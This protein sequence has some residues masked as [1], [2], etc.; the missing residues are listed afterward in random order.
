MS[1]T[2]IFTHIPKTAG[3]S[4]KKSAIFPNVRP[5]D[6][7]QIF[8]VRKLIQDRPR[9][10]SVVFGHFPYGAHV[11]LGPGPFRYLT[12]LRDPVDRAVSFYNYVLLCERGN[13]AH[14][15]GHRW[16]PALPDAKRYPIDAF[17]ELEAY[18]NVQTKFTAGYA[19]LRPRNALP[20]WLLTL[21]ASEAQ[22]LE[23]AQSNLIHRYWY[24]GLLDRIDEAQDVIARALGGTS[25]PMRDRTRQTSGALG[26]VDPS[27]AQRDRIRELNALDV[28][29]YDFARRHYDAQAALT[30]FVSPST[31]A[32]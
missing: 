3:T 26:L 9:G 14:G 19:W 29:L 30:P 32:S 2:L 18:R 8:G 6:V 15:E 31:G 5:R 4:L 11:A 7:Y 23:R 21:V 17:Y 10:A 16:H 28:A 13:P 20:S 25:Q 1:G 12:I 24:F 27:P 22:L